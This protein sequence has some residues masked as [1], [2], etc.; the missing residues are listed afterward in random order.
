V[1][2]SR[3]TIKI[4]W[5]RQTLNCEGGKP[6]VINELGSNLQIGEELD[7]GIEGKLILFLSFF[8]HSFLLP[9]LSISLHIYSFH[10]SSTSFFVAT[11]FGHCPGREW[12]DVFIK[13][14]STICECQ[15]AIGY[16]GQ[17]SWSSRRL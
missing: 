15:T 7:F 1:E 8:L 10:S 17:E 5:H 6:E 13:A 12:G 9:F 2:I 4:D 16:D 3:S 11:N 14:P